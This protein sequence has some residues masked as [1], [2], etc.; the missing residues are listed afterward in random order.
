M[1]GISPMLP[2][3]IGRGILLAISFLFERFMGD[4][5]SAFSFL[6]G[7][8]SDAM[9]FLIPVL[10][11]YIAMSIG[12]RPALMPG[13]VAGL[14]AS[15]GAGFIGGLIYRYWNWIIYGSRNG[16]RHVTTNCY[17]YFL[18]II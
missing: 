3:V 1:N 12:D 15:R 17:C 11:G 5:S 16:W 18:L 8:G 6:N 2:F 9:S 10:A 7:L 13:M 14:M 4:I